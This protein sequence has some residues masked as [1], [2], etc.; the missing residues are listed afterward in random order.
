[1]K[2]LVL[3]ASGFLG[4][5]VQK[6]L[7]LNHEV[8]GTTTSDISQVAGQINFRYSGSNSLQK[9]IHRVNPDSVINCIALADVDQAQADLSLAKF[10]NFELPRDLS[11]LCQSTGIKLIHISTDHFESSLEGLGEDEVPH[12]INIYG[13]TK[14][15]GDLAILR[16]SNSASIVRTNFFAF[17]HSGDK[18]LIDF[19]A[20]SL[21]ASRQVTG[22][23]NVLFNPVGAHFLAECIEKLL[24]SNHHGILNIATSRLLSKYDFLCLVA[25]R[26]LL[27]ST[28]IIPQDYA[29]VA[30]SA[31]RPNCMFLNPSNLLTF[32]DG[33]LPSIESQLDLELSGTI[34]LLVDKDGK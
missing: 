17:S 9:L 31:I 7:S 20:N 13:Q 5:I 15:D 34:P 26:L 1:M 12:P 22:Y 27:D 14:L 4:T 16:N 6:V 30:G 33:K 10:L 29:R 23:R 19:I 28:K 11:V 8:I 25:D 18:G 24:I 21:G 3:G 2:V 32:L